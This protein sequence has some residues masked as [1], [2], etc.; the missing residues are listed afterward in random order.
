D[1]VRAI[2]FNDFDLAGYGP[3]T[4]DLRRLAVGLWIVADMADLKHKQRV[5]LV[6]DMVGGY[7]AEL[8]GLAGGQPP[9]ALRADALSGDLEEVLAPPDGEAKDLPASKEDQALAAAVLAAYPRTLLATRPAA[10]L[11]LKALSRRHAGIS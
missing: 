9:L 7:L 2:E 11:R 8:E 10:E 5:K 3:F 1:R 6:E 4:E